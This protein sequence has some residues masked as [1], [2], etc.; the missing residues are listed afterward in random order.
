MVLTTEQRAT[1]SAR[2]QRQL[3]NLPS[4]HKEPISVTKHDITDAVA[5]IDAWVDAN[6]AS[7]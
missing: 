7:L 3:S 2:F 5:A 4:D 6:M 1:V